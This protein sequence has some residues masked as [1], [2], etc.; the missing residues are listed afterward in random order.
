MPVWRADLHVHT[1]LSG[2]AEV[3][4]IPPLIVERA[5]EQGLTMIGIAD[6]NSA[7]NAAA[8]ME[9][10]GDDVVIKPGLELETKET[11]HL[12]CLFDE[13]EAALELQQFVY[14]HLPATLPERK[15]PFGPRF[16]VN[17]AGERLAEEQRP[18]FAATDLSLGEAVEAARSRGSLVVASHV[19]RRAHGLLGVLGFVPPEVEL[20]ALEAGPG[21]LLSGRIASSDAHRLSDLGSRYTLLEAEGPSVAE[22]RRCIARASF[23]AGVM[24]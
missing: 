21:G 15:D 2:C 7:G 1:V 3:E 14:Q 19:D 18:L 12:V 22:L 10:A 24:V 13:V 20:D 9:A 4:M 5:R 23:R 11:V 17:A 6:H 8:V 16:L